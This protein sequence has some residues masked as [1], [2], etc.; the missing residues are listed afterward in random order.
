M[1]YVNQILSRFSPGERLCYYCLSPKDKS[2]YASY[3][4]AVRYYKVAKPLMSPSEWLFQKEEQ[5]ALTEFIVI[6]KALGL[7]SPQTAY[8]YYKSGLR[9]ILKIVKGNPKKYSAILG[10][11]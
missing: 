5:E 7:D 3:I 6:A 9:R 10:A 11:R 4:S 8:N 1:N 2:A